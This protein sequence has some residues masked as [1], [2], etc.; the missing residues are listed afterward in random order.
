M[1]GPLKQLRV[2]QTWPND[3][4]MASLLS[5]LFFCPR[6]SRQS[7]K[8]KKENQIFYLMAGKYPTEFHHMSVS[9]KNFLSISKTPSILIKSMSHKKTTNQ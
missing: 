2:F 7:C 6:K 3:A 8:K 1:D 5:S 9:I 4:Q